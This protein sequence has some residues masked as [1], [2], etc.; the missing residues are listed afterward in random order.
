VTVDENS[1]GG[2]EFD[3]CSP[4]DIPFASAGARTFYN[5]AEVGARLPR[6][7]TLPNW[8]TLLNWIEE[9]GGGYALK[10]A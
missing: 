2:I 4:V 6:L 1:I 8:P 5:P 7:T 3:F 10:Y 9:Y